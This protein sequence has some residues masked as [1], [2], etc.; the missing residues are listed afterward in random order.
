MF[1]DDL[2]NANGLSSTVRCRVSFVIRVTV[3]VRVMVRFSRMCRV[4]VQC[5][6]TLDPESPTIVQC[7]ENPWYYTG[8]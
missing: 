2:W 1:E 4:R 5:N 8:I 6:F 7:R 3:R